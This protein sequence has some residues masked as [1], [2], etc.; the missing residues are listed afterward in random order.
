MPSDLIVPVYILDAV[1]PHNGANK[2]EIVEV[3]GWQV[4]TQKGLHTAGEKVVYFPPDSLIPESLADILGVTQ[5]LSFSVH[6]K[7]LGRVKSINLR[8]E[9]SHGFIARIEKVAE[10]Y[11]DI[12]SCVEGDNVA[13]KLGIEKWEPIEDTSGSHPDQGKT[14]R[15]RL[16]NPYFSKYTDIQNL[17]HYKS[18]FTEEDE[19]TIS[20]KVHGSN[21]RI[22]LLKSSN[23]KWY[24][25]WTWFNRY[26][27]CVGSHNV[28]RKLTDMGV[29]GTGFTDCVKGMIKEIQR[30]KGD[31]VI[32]F[33]EVFG[34]NIQDLT[35]GREN[36][37]FR[38][39]DIKVGEKYLDWKDVVY[40]CKLWKVETVPVL[41]EGKF[42]YDKVVELS[43]GKTT[44][45][46]ENAHIR[47]GVV[48]KTLVESIHPKIG[49]KILKYVSDDYLTRK[50]GTERH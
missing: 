2:L 44:L 3:G 4:V 32:V 46:D 19:V 13:E 5:Y 35:Y 39:F 7:G 47:E 50:G 38:V 37:E 23:F 43:K 25:P 42:N 49:R 11:P 10:Y 8:K 18:V 45:M 15:K 9:P 24:K 22:S 28:Q 26:E 40:Y 29:Y 21:C 14:E 6:R 31:N 16:C 48:V 36:P 17:R 30:D 20:C 34:S 33:G 27:W 12:I 1:K 41:Y